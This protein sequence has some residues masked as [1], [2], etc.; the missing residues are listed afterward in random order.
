[1]IFIRRKFPLFLLLFLFLNTIASVAG[2]EY[3]QTLPSNTVF[4]DDFSQGLSYCSAA[5]GS[6][7][8]FTQD[9]CGAVNSTCEVQQ[10]TSI[11]WSSSGKSAEIRDHGSGSFGIEDFRRTFA[12]DHTHIYSATWVFAFSCNMQTNVGTQD[13]GFSLEY[14]DNANPAQHQEFRVRF[15]PNQKLWQYKHGA[16]VW[17]NIVFP[18]GTR[19]FYPGVS[20]SSSSTPHYNFGWEFVTITGT[21]STGTYTSVQTP[22]GLW[23]CTGATGL[24]SGCVPNND[25][26]QDSSC[27][28]SNINSCMGIETQIDAS[29]SLCTGNAGGWNPSGSY[30]AAFVGKE[31]VLD[32]TNGATAC[33]GGGV[34]VVGGTGTTSSVVTPGCV[35]VNTSSAYLSAGVLAT[36]A[37]AGVLYKLGYL[38][39]TRRKR[40]EDPCDTEP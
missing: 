23:T 31:L 34:N 13:I 25:E 40:R 30:C 33:G 8:Y 16:G 38:T 37:I 18:S 6:C 28:N 1:M 17:S 26:G 3:V 9:N 14:P 20:C 19:A 5:P 7:N 29:V 10:N 11:Y 32:V 35:T 22:E 36:V 27:G 39:V 4:F 15:Q 12:A 2:S 21:P 24:T